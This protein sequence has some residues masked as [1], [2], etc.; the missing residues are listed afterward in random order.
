MWKH[1]QVPDVPSGDGRGMG[2]AKEYQKLVRSRLRDS[3]SLW[4]DL[5]AITNG[6]QVEIRHRR[7]ELTC[8]RTI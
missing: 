6:T 4:E 7:I 8:P 2:D 3:A 5:R 1:C